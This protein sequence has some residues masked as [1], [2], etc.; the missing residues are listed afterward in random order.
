MA[1]TDNVNQKDPLNVKELVNK[2]RAVY[3][4]ITPPLEPANNGKY[5]VIEASSGKYFIGDTKDEAMELARKEF[6]H[7]LLFVRKI[8]E[9]EKASRHF[10]SASLSSSKYY[11]LL[12]WITGASEIK[13]T[14]K[15]RV[16]DHKR[17]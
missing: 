10:S 17:M 16:Y 14:F 11:H 2:A 9:L 4:A 5:I 13:L 3:G 15:N 1:D 8:G 7:I 6:P 12:K